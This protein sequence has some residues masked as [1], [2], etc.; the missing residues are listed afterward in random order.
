MTAKFLLGLTNPVSSEREAEFNRWYS[1]VHLPEVAALPGFRGAKRFRATELQSGSG[2]PQYRYLALYELDDIELA[3][4]ALDA[5]SHLQL[6][7][8]IDPQMIVVAMEEIIPP[9]VL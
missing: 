6:S 1:D 9:E 8:A 2:V 4:G 7:T 3:V 5:A